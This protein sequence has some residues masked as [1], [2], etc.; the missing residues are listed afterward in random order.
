MTDAVKLSDLKIFN[1][2]R[3]VSLKVGACRGNI[4]LG[5]AGGL[6]ERS[7]GI[8]SSRQG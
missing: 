7:R 6:T 8:G 3:R 1:L 4:L 5:E 2:Q